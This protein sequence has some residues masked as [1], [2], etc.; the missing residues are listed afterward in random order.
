MLASSSPAKLEHASNEGAPSFQG[1]VYS[2]ALL[3]TGCVTEGLFRR[4]N[5]ATSRVLRAN[6]CET[7][8]P[9]GQVCCG[10]LH[11]HAG[12]L[13][14]ARHLARRN[15]DAFESADSTTRLSPTPA[16]AARCCFLTL[17][18]WKAM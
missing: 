1:K 11:A 3:F 17:I 5:R 13:E 10:A 4:V 2:K 9:R 18:Y 7:S 15:V 6:G 12:D 16:A 8:I 14:G